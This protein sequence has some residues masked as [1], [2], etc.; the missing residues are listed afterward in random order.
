MIRQKRVLV[1]LVFFQPR[2]DILARDGA[3]GPRRNV[4]KSSWT[5]T[6]QK[7]VTNQTLILLHNNEE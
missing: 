6:E 1:S 7:L 4:E 3:E 2:E 5:Q